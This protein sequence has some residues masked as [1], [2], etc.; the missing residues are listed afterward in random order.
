MALQNPPNLYSGGQGVF[1]S[2]PVLM[3]QANLMAK[4]KAKE[5]ALEA[6]YGKSL[7]D[8]TPAGMRNK[9]IVGGWSQQLEEFKN[10]GMNPE[11]KKYLLNPSLD[12]HKTVTEFN[13]RHTKLLSDAELSKQALKQEVDIYDLKKSGKLDPDNDDIVLF[14][15]IGK[16]IYDETRNDE[17][18]NAPDMSN[19]SYFVPEFD[20]ARQAK[21]D[22]LIFGNIKGGKTYDEKNAINDN[23][24]G[25]VIMPYV[26]TYST[27]N[28][29]QIGNNAER[30]VSS[31]KSMRKA[32]NDLLHNDPELVAKATGFLQGVE[33]KNAVVD[34][35]AKLAKADYMMKAASYAKRGEEVKTD[36]KYQM[37]KRYDNQVNFE[38]NHKFPHQVALANIYSKIRRA[39]SE[40][41]QNEAYS[42]LE[43][44]RLNQI[45]NGSK[46][47]SMFG[48]L[49]ID[50]DN[51]IKLN[52]SPTDLENF[53]VETPVV[54]ED[55]KP[56]TDKNGKPLFTK[57]K[58][59]DIFYNMKTEEYTPVVD[60]Y[61]GNKFKKDGWLVSY[62]NGA[63]N[64]TPK[65]N[66]LSGGGVKSG[67]TK[68]GKKSSASSSKSDRPNLPKKWDQFK[69]K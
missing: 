3:F 39:D 58:A 66:M 8:V 18:G 9:D 56:K 23:K 16:S 64:T 68:E 35:P 1:D 31:D 60:G 25:Q 42:N 13:R 21:A 45:K 15:R 32:Y 38:D 44:Y 34:T 29:E 62:V 7:Q 46:L 24:T 4:K 20:N 63:A 17:F 57:S 14:D 27:E 40:Y 54:D 61:M 59:K 36:W 2:R 49:G 22:K 50:T 5:D 67:G 33:G 53:D 65:I 51:T 52:V 6:Y 47:P 19:M 26:E 37:E 55:G 12:G 11:N 69:R 43:N 10:F 48:N 41:K 30:A 28:I